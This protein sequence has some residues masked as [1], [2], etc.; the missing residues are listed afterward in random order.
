VGGFTVT[1]TEVNPSNPF[2]GCY[3]VNR[4]QLLTLIRDSA[5]E[6]PRISTDEIRDKINEDAV[7][8]I[9]TVVQAFYFA[10]QCNARVL[11]CIRA[12]TGLDICRTGIEC[13]AYNSGMK[14]KRKS[15]YSNQ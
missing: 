12:L 14:R 6:P 1:S 5:V 15:L 3:P 2:T 9:M 10:I 4:H 13:L 11:V 7:L 8:K